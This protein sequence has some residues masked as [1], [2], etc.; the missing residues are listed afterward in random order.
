MTTTIE[1]T[2]HEQKED[3]MGGKYERTFVVAVPVERAWRAFVDPEER[4]NYVVPPGRNADGWEQGELETIVEKMP[5]T[6]IEL[7]KIES[8]RSINYREGVRFNWAKG[9]DSIT[10]WLDVTVTFEQEGTG[11]RITFTRSGFGDSAEWRLFQEAQSLGMDETLYDLVLYLET[12]VA[13]GRHFHSRPA[14]NLGASMLE[15]RRGVQ[16]VAIVPGGFAE[17]A[18]LRA[19]DTLVRLAGASVFRRSDVVAL[20][21]AFAPGTEV[22]VDFV[23]EG[24]LLTG[25]AALS[26]EHYAANHGARGG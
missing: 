16:V 23:R 25:R 1:V 18:G 7:G 5:S 17:E 12:G 14:G 2:M 11:T 26:A 4:K 9:D 20:Q 15:S 24:R 3:A 10:D 8:M 19:G 13:G 22:E 6:K 21:R